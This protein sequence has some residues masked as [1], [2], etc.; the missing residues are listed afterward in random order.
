MQNLGGKVFIDLQEVSELPHATSYEEDE[1]EIAMN[2]GI[3]SDTVRRIRQILGDMAISLNGLPD[4]EAY[5]IAMGHCSGL[6][7]YTLVLDWLQCMKDR[8]I[9]PGYPAYLLCFNAINAFLWAGSQI[10]SNVRARCRNIS[11]ELL[12]EM[13]AH[14]IPISRNV[15]ASVTG[16]MKCGTGRDF[17]W[18]YNWMFGVDVDRPDVPPSSP[19]LADLTCWS[20]NKLIDFFGYHGNLSKMLQ[21]FEVLTQPLPNRVTGGDVSSPDDLS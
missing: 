4:R 18:W 7:E 20:L 3:E 2:E 19:P 15:V 8:A 10:P 21:T 12:K 16:I 14:G 13:H 17:C 5:L 1:R 11:K 6:G 9:N